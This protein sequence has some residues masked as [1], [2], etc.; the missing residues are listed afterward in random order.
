MADRDTRGFFGLLFAVL[1]GF[2]WMILPFAG[3]LLAAAVI[4]VLA[5]PMHSWLQARIRR[6]LVVDVLSFSAI[7][8]GMGATI[9]LL[10]GLVLPQLGSLAR[11]MA[12]ALQPGVVDAALARVIPARMDAVAERFLGTGIGTSLS[13]GLRTSAIDAASGLAAAVPGLL[14][15]TGWAF[16]QAVVFLLALWSFLRDGEQL[17]AWML[18]VAP[19]NPNYSRR[20]I[21]IF[22][23]FS[24]NVVLAGAVGSAIQGAVAGVGYAL[25]GLDRVLLF[26]VLT[27]GVAFVPYVGSALVWVPLCAMLLSQGRTGAAVF[28]MIWSV[29]LIAC[30]DNLVM[31]FLVRGKSELH[32]LLVFLGVFGGFATMGIIGLLVGPMV[33]AMV[34]ALFT[35]YE[36]RRGEH[37]P[38]GPLVG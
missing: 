22:A 24:R 26:A 13:D 6:P 17:L 18:R 30:I 14:E 9:A 11:T 38:P 1:F 2:V 35:I 5:W 10:L 25:V 33:A 8:L 3:T 21:T 19:L 36:E 23:E 7:T 31:P 15:V 27:G 34:V 20:L 32:P 12:E 4:V 29:T 28:L 16:V 37:A